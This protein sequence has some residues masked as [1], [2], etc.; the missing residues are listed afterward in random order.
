MVE[1]SRPVATAPD[2]TV[3]QSLVRDDYRVILKVAQEALGLLG[4]GRAVVLQLAHPLIAAGVADYSGFQADPLARLQ[5]TL[6]LMHTVV[7]GSPRDAERALRRF[8]YIHERMTGRLS[9]D[10][11]RFPSGTP[12]CASD[13][14]LKMWVHATVVETGWISYEQFVRP[15]SSL[16]R[17]R[18]YRETSDVARLM[19]IPDSILPRTLNEFRTYMDT[20]LASDTLAV[21][22]DARLLA[23]HVLRPTGVG[24]IPAACARLLAFTT[25]GLLPER[26]RADF[27]LKWSRQHQLFFDVLS[28]STRAMRPVSPRWIWQ[29]PRMGNGLARHLL[30]A[31]AG[32]SNE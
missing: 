29:S 2:P 21:S 24:T 14:E 15:L 5:R 13:P 28:T 9:Q 1:T 25:S 30:S 6:D 23:R 27:G 18:Y 20:M 8:H 10:V 31:A 11:G 26:F 16:E 12:Y 22:D 3:E 32:H 19:G 4:A 17:E 7:F